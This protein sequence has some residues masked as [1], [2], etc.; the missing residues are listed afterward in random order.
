MFF[1]SFPSNNSDNAPNICGTLSR[2]YWSNFSYIRRL[3]LIAVN[4]IFPFAQT[5]DRSAVLKFTGPLISYA[6]L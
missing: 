1:Y 4:K 5:N 3:T 2:F 6:A